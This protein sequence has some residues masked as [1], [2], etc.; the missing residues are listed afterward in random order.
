V[1]Q[2][3]A[4]HSYGR[5]VTSFPAAARR[6]RDP[7]LAVR[8]RLLSLREC[9]VHFGPYGFRATWHHLIVSAHIPRRLEDDP[10]S[11]NRAVTELEEARQLWMAQSAAFV[12]R[13]RAEKAAG[14]RSPRRVERWY[15]WAGRLAYCPDPEVHPEER[16]PVV[17]QRLIE[18]YSSG[19]DW[20]TNCPA[21]GCARFENE[22]CPRC[23]VDPRDPAAA[24]APD[25]RA[26]LAY[27]WREIW[28]RTAFLEQRRDDDQTKQQAE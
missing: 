19:A 16:L 24:L 3:W 23:G 21:C 1:S 27:R 7:D 8:D 15:S 6:V 5:A 12:A 18:A 11:L 14:R 26:R 9:V 2:V 28:Q 22:T 4:G 17:I 10:E 13:R 25:I 20:S